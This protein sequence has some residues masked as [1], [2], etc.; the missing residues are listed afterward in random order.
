M[1]W[2]AT[3]GSANI[4]TTQN[5]Q[6]YTPHIMIIPEQYIHIMN[7]GENNHK[8][9]N[10]I[11][12]LTI[13]SQSLLDAGSKSRQNSSLIRILCINS[14]S[15]QLLSWH[16]LSH[17][18][19]NHL[20]TLLIYQLVCHISSHHLSSYLSHRLT[21]VHA[22]SLSVIITSIVIISAFFGKS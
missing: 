7:Q 9:I 4:S 6:H 13:W 18:L 5:N 1:L 20:L 12:T 19:S 15:V 22:L 3:P 21:F 17:R 14:P 11:S 2:D 8:N 10:Q 16:H